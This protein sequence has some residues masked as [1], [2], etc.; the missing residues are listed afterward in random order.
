MFKLLLKQGGFSAAVVAITG[1]LAPMIV[2]FVISYYIFNF[3]L[4][5]SLFIGGTLT[6][7][8]LILYI[9]T[10]FLFAPII[11]KIFAYLISFI[12]K[13]LN[14]L[15]FVP[16]VI[17]AIILV[18]A[19]AAAFQ[20]DREIIHKIEESLNPLIWIFTPIFFVYVGLQIN[21]RAIDFASLHLWA[22]SAV[23]LVVAIATKLLAGLSVKGTK[24][25][26]NGELQWTEM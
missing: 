25:E 5:S 11:G 16:P 13:K 3:P 2:G 4:M 10:F 23:L 17:I 20:T 18:F 12:T 9:G 19:F 15:D 26:K 14:T 24:K 22:L 21:L 7:T 6:A 8:L 1:A